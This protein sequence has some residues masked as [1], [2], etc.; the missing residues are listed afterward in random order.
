MAPIYFQR[1]G[2][3]MTIVG[4]E[5]RSNGERVLLVFD[6]SFAVAETL[7]QLRN[8]KFAKSKIDSLMAAFRQDEAKLARFKEYE[9]MM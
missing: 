3:S 9:I 5:R 2:H 7:R 1:P 4:M 6:P 8:G